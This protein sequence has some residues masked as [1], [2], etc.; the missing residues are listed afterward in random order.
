MAILSTVRFKDSL[1]E[2]TLSHPGTM[3]LGPREILSCVLTTTSVW[4]VS[5]FSLLLEEE[6]M[7]KNWR[8][9]AYF[10][11]KVREVQCLLRIWALAGE[12]VGCSAFVLEQQAHFPCGKI[13]EFPPVV[14]TEVVDGSALHTCLAAVPLHH[15]HRNVRGEK[16]G[17][18]RVV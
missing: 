6:E 7:A 11:E 17:E 14:T 2:K 5:K 16:E 12:D 8:R 4:C 15:T 10:R 18:E 3:W 9:C 13:M 1:V